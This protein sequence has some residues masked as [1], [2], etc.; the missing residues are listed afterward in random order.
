[1]PS[2]TRPRLQ[3]Q[4]PVATEGRARRVRRWRVVCSTTRVSWRV[5]SEVCKWR[6]GGGGRA[7]LAQWGR[8]GVLGISL[9]VRTA[10]R[11][12]PTNVRGARGSAAEKK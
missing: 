4:Q 10:V 9:V 3:R 5:E 8:E 7:D 11:Y 2:C 6:G 12:R 1:M